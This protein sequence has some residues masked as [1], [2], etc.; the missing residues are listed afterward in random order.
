MALVRRSITSL[1]V[2]AQVRL[3]RCPTTTF[4]VFYGAFR[5]I[6]C[7]HEFA[8]RVIIRGGRALAQHA[9]LVYLLRPWLF[10]DAMHFLRPLL[11]ERQIIHVFA[12]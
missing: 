2:G 6:C 5:K 7:H 3:S 10:L 12:T 1:T 9:L 4:H 11:N 8:P